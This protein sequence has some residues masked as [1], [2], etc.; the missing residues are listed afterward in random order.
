[1]VTV[2]G[3]GRRIDVSFS[4]LVACVVWFWLVRVK[5]TGAKGDTDSKRKKEQFNTLFSL[6]TVL[7][8]FWKIVFIE[9]LRLVIIF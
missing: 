3:V 4:F 6:H 2:G 8:T 9:E 1:M 5:M 7:K